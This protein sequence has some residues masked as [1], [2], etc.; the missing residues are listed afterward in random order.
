MRQIFNTWSTNTKTRLER[1]KS[2]GTGR[3]FSIPMADMVSRRSYN[4]GKIVIGL[5]LLI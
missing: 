4:F 1:F 5:K 3:W 2:R